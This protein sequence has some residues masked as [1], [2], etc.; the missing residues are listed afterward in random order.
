ME[1]HPT[2]NVAEKAGV[3]DERLEAL[4]LDGILVAIAVLAIGYVLGNVTGGSGFGGLLLAMYLGIPVGMF[5]YHVG[6]EG[7]YG[8]T[9]GKAARGIV[10]AKSDGSSVSWFGAFARNLLRPLDG[11]PAF[12]LLGIV[13]AYATDDDQRIGDLAGDTV[14]VQTAE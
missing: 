4:F 8:Q 10:V 14:V 11:L 1:R 9:L 5:A 12:Y 2:P 13:V 3:L 6:M 7:Y